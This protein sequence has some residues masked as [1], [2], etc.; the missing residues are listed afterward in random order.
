MNHN[1]FLNN[2]HVKQKIKFILLAVAILAINIFNFTAAMGQKG[3]GA[4]GKKQKEI[5]LIVEC[6]QYT[7]T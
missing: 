3:K 7:V 4:A 2:R 5:E 6:V 1:A